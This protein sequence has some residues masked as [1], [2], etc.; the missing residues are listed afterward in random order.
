MTNRPRTKEEFDNWYSESGG[1]PWNYQ[2]RNIKRR[3]SDSLKFISKFIDKDFTGNIIELGAFTGDFTLLLAGHFPNA[4]I[5]ANDISDAALKKAKEKAADCSNIIFL[6]KDLLEFDNSSIKN[7][8]KKNI[9]LLLECLY[10]LNGNERE[11]AVENLINNFPNSDI[12]ISA[13]IIGGNYFTEELLS[14]MMGRNNYYLQ[15]FRVLNLKMFS[16]LRKVLT[17]AAE[18]NYTFRKN[19]ANQVIYYFKPKEIK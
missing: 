3:L 6:Q 17:P 8:T 14:E 9:L 13:P 4:Q 2:S 19:L 5:Y 10:Y 12:F 7:S 18:K 1:D 11:P 15:S 16:P